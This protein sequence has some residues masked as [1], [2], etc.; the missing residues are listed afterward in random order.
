MGALDF[1][2]IVKNGEIYRFLTCLF[3]NSNPL[4]MIFEE[5]LKIWIG[6]ACEKSTNR[7]MTFICYFFA[8]LGGN[9]LGEN[10]YL[11]NY[12]RVIDTGASI[13]GILSIILF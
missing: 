6:V 4:L 7:W 2:K 12:Q 11:N 5:I 10:V 9:L 8:S 3:V 13:S 1:Q